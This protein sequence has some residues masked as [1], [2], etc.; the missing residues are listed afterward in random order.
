M[1][2]ILMAMGSLFVGVACVPV[3]AQQVTG[4][5][6]VLQ[7]HWTATQ[8]VRDG[9]AAG[10]VV[11]HRI[12]F[13][14]DRFRIESGE[15]K[16]LHEGTFLDDRH[17]VP[18]SIDFTHAQGTLKGKTWRGIYA[19]EGD[20]LKVCDNAPDLARPRPAAFEACTRTGYVLITFRR[21]R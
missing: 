14:G 20:T 10:D 7:G 17:A 1:R 11:G 21:A 8:A 5:H 2:R 19:V 9:Q 3:S 18:S 4:A 6:D 16:P 15:G 12:T 13:E